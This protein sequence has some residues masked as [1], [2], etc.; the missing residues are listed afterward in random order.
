MSA[1][2]RREPEVVD[3]AGVWFPPPLIY[4]G[5]FALAI[6]AGRIRPL[7]VPATAE[8]RTAVSI[9]FLTLGFLLVSWAFMNFL[10]AGTTP[11]PHRPSNALVTSGPFGWSRNP[12]YLSLAL[13]HTGAA[14]LI[15]SLWAILVLPVA[16]FFI[17]RCVVSREE[18]YLERKFGE[19]YREYRR[20]VRRWL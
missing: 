17:D 16:I 13:V 10:R 11:F 9:A 15:N 12:M 8:P 14:L 1:I 4:V 2:S 5:A 7:P 6:A 18:R 3:S 20:R 19:A